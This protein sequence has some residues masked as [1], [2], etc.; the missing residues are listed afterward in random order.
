MVQAFVSGVGGFTLK[1]YTKKNPNNTY[2][3]ETM[4][5]SAT[6]F[7]SGCLCDSQDANLNL[8]SPS[9]GLKFKRG[10]GRKVQT[11]YE[12]IH[13]WFMHICQCQWDGILYATELK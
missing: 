11:N 4:S 12:N 5:T 13:S 2:T 10:C 9:V 3:S 6:W 8:Q 7:L 1:I